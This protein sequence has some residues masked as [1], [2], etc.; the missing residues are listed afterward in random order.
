MLQINK[1]RAD[2]VIDFAAEELKKYLRMMMPHILEI[3]ITYDPEAKDGFRLG[4][5]EDFGL[6]T[7]VSEPKYDDVVHID[8]DTEGGILAGSNPRSVLFAVYRFLKLNGCRFLFPGFDGEYI[9]MKNIQPQKYHKVADYRERGHAL[10]GDP[11][12]EQVLDF[13]DWHAKEEM[14][15]F[16]CYGIHNYMIRYYNHRNNEA[17][18]TPE[19]LDFETADSQWRTLFEYEAKKRGLMVRCGG[20]SLLPK[21]IG[22]DVSK[23]AEYKTGGREIE[24]EF[25]PYLAQLN[26]ERKLNR[27]D[28]FFTNLCMSNPEVRKKVIAQVMKNYETS[29]DKTRVGISLADTSHNHCECENCRTKRPSD[30]LVVMLNEL[31]EEL[32]RRG[33]DDVKVKFSFYVDTMF[34]PSVERFNNPDRFSLTFC[35]ISRTYHASIDSFDN[36]PEPIPYQYNAWERP[37]SMEEVYSLLNE[38][39]KV[40]PGEICVYEYHFWVH[41]YRDPG[42]M[43]MSRRLYEDTRSYKPCGMNG[44]MQDGSNKSFF[45][46]GFHGHIY[47]EVL[48]NRDVDYEEALADYFSHLYGDD[49]KIVRNYL[50][51][52]T[53]AFCHKYMT[54]ELPADPD[55]D[56]FYNPDRVQYLNQVK[57]IT[58]QMRPIIEA[59]MQMPTRPQNVAWRILRRHTEYADGLAEIMKEKCVGHNMEALELLKQFRND[60]GKYDFELERYFDFG[61]FTHSFTNI[62]KKMPNIEL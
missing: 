18:R 5:L 9:P 53:E 39:R 62:I 3:E 8:T 49:W 13:I 58:A 31:D 34:A 37:K 51:R 25:K 40:F 14:N 28:I 12:V 21:A 15:S 41:Q 36:L 48:M 43:S 46:H 57:D 61:M 27:N 32:T 20:H 11:S 17:N 33:L 24:D 60:F 30:W 45:P 56:P 47:N 2:H 23:R 54:G 16:G 29:A 10:E 4:L 35:P 44:C 1:L 59:H 6:P 7:E 22:I 26:G 38:W 52:I 50:D 19:G 55:K 42:L